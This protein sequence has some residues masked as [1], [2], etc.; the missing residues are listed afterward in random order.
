MFQHGL[1]V[2]AA[3]MITVVF[4]GSSCGQEPPSTFTPQPPEPAEEPAAAKPQPAPAIANT[5]TFIPAVK[6]SSTS[7]VSET[8]DSPPD[9]S[10]T[11]APTD[12]LWAGDL[13]PEPGQTGSLAPW[14]SV[15]VRPGENPDEDAWRLESGPW[16][17]WLPRRRRVLPNANRQAGNCPT[18]RG[19]RGNSRR[20]CRTRVDLRS[21]SKARGSQSVGPSLESLPGTSLLLLTT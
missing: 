15:R 19:S 6:G 2:A 20:S 4:V 9:V 12:A 1:L 13:A 10:S 18:A 8:P 7:K 17:S 11:F 3:A 5:P 21:S 14:M 16:P